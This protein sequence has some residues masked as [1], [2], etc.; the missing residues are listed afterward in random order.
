[1]D[2]RLSKL[3]GVSGRAEQRPPPFRREDAPDWRAVPWQDPAAFAV[4]TEAEKTEWGELMAAFHAPGAYQRHKDDRGFYARLAALDN[5]IDWHA[6][7][8]RWRA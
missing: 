6:G 3:E 5:K 4:L 1:M 8:P 2:R 7:A